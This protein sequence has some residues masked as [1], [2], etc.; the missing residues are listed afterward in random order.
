MKKTVRKLI[1]MLL[2]AT[3]LINLTACGNEQEPVKTESTETEAKVAA[4]D[5]STPVEEPASDESGKY[6][7]DIFMKSNSGDFWAAVESGAKDAGEK[8]D[9]VVSVYACDSETNY[10]QQIQQIESSISRGV[11]A[12]AVACLDSE[13][14]APVVEEAANKG[15]KVIS[16]NGILNSEV[17]LTHVATDNYAAG[18]M[19][20]EALAKAME[21]KG[22][23]VVLGA[24]EGVKNNR[25]RSEGCI[26]YI[27]ENYPDME[28]ISSQYMD[29]DMSIA[30]S[31]LNDWIT[32]NPD[33]G[34]IFTNN[35]TGTIA[36][37]TVLEERGK[38]GEIQHV[39][40]DATVQT[41]TQ[42]T[43]GITDSIVSQQPYKM[44]YLSVEKCIALLDGEEIEKSIDT[45]V[46]LVTEENK[47]SEEVNAI[48][49]PGA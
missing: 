39:G 43:E 4:S 14:L 30:T 32:A 45:R 41:V 6:A 35:E 42:I 16:F 10:E 13:A 15:I 20:G 11:D 2:T 12:I 5:E 26:A 18:E 34:G 44:G 38:I 49:N 21:G 37:A 29:N 25:D 17:I 24:A 36:A 22:K 3:M 46:L 8:L 28:L 40:F 19:A 31:M 27:T 23:Y 47:D 33:L 7:I 48:I 9:A 1:M